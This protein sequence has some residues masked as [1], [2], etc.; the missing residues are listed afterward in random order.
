MSRS[1]VWVDA[2]TE[3]AFGGNPCAVVFDAAAMSVADRLAFTQET[4][5]SECAFIVGSDRADFGVRYYLASREILMAG[6]PTIATVAALIDAGLVDL[7]SGAAAFT[8]EIGAGVM[9]IRVQAR[10]GRPPLITMTQAAPS[11][12]RRW[13][14]GAVAALVGLT[15]ADV[16]APPRT[17]STGTPFCVTVLRDLAA[18]RRARLN[19]EALA[20]FGERDFFEPFL[21]VLQGFT[22]EGRTA[23]RLLLEPPEPAE[24]PFTGAATGAMAAY[25]WA[26]GMIDAP[27]F[28]AE[29][30]HDMGRPGR[31]AVRVLGARDAIAGVDVAGSGV[32]LMRGTLAD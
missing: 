8:L 19:A 18:L 14:A 17:A 22:P 16:A 6:H 3:V 11:F 30:G 10:E 25:L 2:F 26:E 1:F 29:Q 12:G 21:C 13:D 4:R 28:I 23:A 15:A 9:P 31:A 5:L 32:V 20:A 27:D 24:D 7:S